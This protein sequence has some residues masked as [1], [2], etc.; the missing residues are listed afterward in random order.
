MRLFLCQF[1]IL[2]HLEVTDWKSANTLFKSV[3]SLIRI[4]LLTY[5][6]KTSMFIASAFLHI[7][8]YIIKFLYLQFNL[9]KNVI[10]SIYDILVILKIGNTNISS[11]FIAIS[12]NEVILVKSGLE[13]FVSNMKKIDSYVKSKTYYDNHFKEHNIFYHQNPISGKRYTFQKIRNEKS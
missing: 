9:L 7:Q 2:L 11:L 12:D 10:Y 3:P 1:I 8:I 5:S 6:P 13:D 4:G